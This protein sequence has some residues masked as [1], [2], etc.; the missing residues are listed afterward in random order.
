MSLCACRCHGGTSSH[1]EP[2]LLDDPVGTATACSKCRWRHFPTP[3]I[4]LPAADGYSYD[5]TNDVD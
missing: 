4:Q 2:P 5:P 3:P 1:D